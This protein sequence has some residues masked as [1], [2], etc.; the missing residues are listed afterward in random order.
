M[1][2]AFC[3]F[4]PVLIAVAAL[5]ACGGG[6]DGES[7]SGNTSAGQSGSGGTAPGE[8]PAVTDAGSVTAPFVKAAS[9]RYVWNGVGTQSYGSLAGFT[10]SASGAVTVINGRSLTG[11]ST[12]LDINGDAGYAQGRWTKGVVTSGGTTTTLDGV[13]NAAYHYILANDLASLPAS[14]TYAC[15]AG[16]FTAPT[17]VGGT[18]VGAAAFA[19]TTSGTA[20]LSFTADGAAVGVTLTSSAGGQ[21]GSVSGNATIKSPSSASLTGTYIGGGAGTQLTLGDG[22]GG[23]VLVVAPYRVVLANGALYQGIASFACAA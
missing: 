8:K 23:K 13:S 20:T 2:Y 22:G 16:R 6:G 10:Q 19:G 11:D 7:S 9:A 18:N 14:G 15:G 12:T 21:Q 3:K 17:F 5:A 1:S 4:A